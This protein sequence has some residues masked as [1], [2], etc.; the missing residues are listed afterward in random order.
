[1]PLRGVKRVA[2][3]IIFASVPMEVDRSGLF[4]L[5]RVPVD[6]HGMRFAGYRDVSIWLIP[7][8]K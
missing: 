7:P 6:R 5:V 8:R 3:E 2:G 4:W 1:M